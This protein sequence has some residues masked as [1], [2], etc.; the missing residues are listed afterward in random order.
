M[1]GKPRTLEATIFKRETMRG[2]KQGKEMVGE[3]AG[4]RMVRSSKSYILLR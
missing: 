1:R 3:K 4:V 2:Q